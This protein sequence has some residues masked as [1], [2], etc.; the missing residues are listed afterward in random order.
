MT[1]QDSREYFQLLQCRE[2]QELIELE[3][4][5]QDKSSNIM[6]EQECREYFELQELIELERE[7][8]EKQTS[9]LENVKSVDTLMESGTTA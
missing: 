7:R 2:L 6:T 1:D 8:Q 3:R 5:W 4:K 9:D